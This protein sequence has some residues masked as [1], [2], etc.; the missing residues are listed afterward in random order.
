MIKVGLTG[1]IGS[2]KTI[3]CKVFELLGVGVYY[4]DKKAKEILNTGEV[5]NEIEKIFGNSVFDD[6]YNIIN[7]KLAEKIF[8][9]KQA[10]QKINS[11]IHPKV[12]DDFKL[13]AEKHESKPYVIQEAAILFETGSYKDF[14]VIV[15]V[16]SSEKLM[17]D[18][19][20]K[21]DDASIKDVES[22]LNNQIAQE[23]KISKADFVLNNNEEELLIP[24]IIDVHKKICENHI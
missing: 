11:I 4:A 6:N 3:S 12:R 21:R 8:N 19:V 1:N 10:L 22:R 13:W 15:L 24:Q 2:G 20:C 5:K 9:D 23:E 18:R 17:I 7:K 16:V 14:N